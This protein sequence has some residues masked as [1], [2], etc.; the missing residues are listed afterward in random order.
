VGVL[1]SSTGKHLRFYILDDVVDPASGGVLRV[2]NQQIVYRSGPD[3]AKCQKWCGYYHS[4]PAV[5][6]DDACRT[7]RDLWVVS[8]DL[9]GSERYPIF[10]G[11]PRLTKSPATDSSGDD[12]LSHRTR[13]SF[14]YEWEHFDR[15]LTEYAREANNYFRMVDNDVLE[16]AVVLDAGCGSGRWAR[17]V[18]SRGVTRLYAVDFSRAIDRAATALADQQNVHCIEADIRRLPFRAEAFEFAYCLGVLHHLATPDEGMREV[19][20]VLKQKGQLLIYLY[21]SLENRP[22]LLRWLLKA[23]AGARRVTVRL[24][25][26][27]ML[28]LAWVIALAIYW[29]L[30]RFSTALWRLG[31][32]RFAENL[33]LG[34]YKDSSIRLMAGDAFDRFATP[35]ERRY[36]RSAIRAWLAHYGFGVRFSDSTPYWVGLAGRSIQP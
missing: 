5:V 16:G 29:P 3:V 36:S 18:A 32:A 11:I 26:P 34:H 17:H 22:R 21:Y 7:C 31:L 19:I 35:I 6:P 28:G 12:G 8:G 10:G 13:E 23:V 9:R 14:G 27:V 33:P 4:R 24:P 25:K 15:T 20:R 30:A 2:E 1:W